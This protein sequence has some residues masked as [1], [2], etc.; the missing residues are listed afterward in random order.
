METSAHVPI[1]VIR[2]YENGFYDCDTESVNNSS[3][4]SNEL[5]IYL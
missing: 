3:D 4:D 1:E 5:H 2:K